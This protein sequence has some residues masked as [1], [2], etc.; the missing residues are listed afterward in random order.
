MLFRSIGFNDN[1]IKIFIPDLDIISSI[2]IFNDRV[3][4]VLKIKITG[5]K[6]EIQHLQTSNIIS[7]ETYQKIKVK[8]MIKMYESHLFRKIQFF[9]IE[10][11]LVDLLD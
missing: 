5:D 2:K 8:T 11:N 3:K 7:L 10:P 4:R 9:I 1:R 6:I